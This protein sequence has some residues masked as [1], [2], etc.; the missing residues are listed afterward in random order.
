MPIYVSSTHVQDA[1]PQIERHHFDYIPQHDAPGPV[2]ARF[3]SESTV[4][5]SAGIP[6][7]NQGREENLRQL[8]ARY[9]CHPDAQV[10]MVSMEA[11]D[12]GRF[13]IV[14]MLESD[15]VF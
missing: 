14:I 12:A 3:H 1:S 5:S 4:C 11:G 10:G 6:T 7:L 8:A 2:Q 15:E 9:L 13:K